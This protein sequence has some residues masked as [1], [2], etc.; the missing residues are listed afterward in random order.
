MDSVS[1]KRRVCSISE[2]SWKRLASSSTLASSWRAGGG[3]EHD[4]RRVAGKKD[5]VFSHHLR[6]RDTQKEG[7]N[8]WGMQECVCVCVNVFVVVHMSTRL[9]SQVR[10]CGENSP[11]ERLQPIGRVNI[12]THTHI[13]T[14]TH[15]II[16]GSEALYDVVKTLENLCV[17]TYP[18]TEM[19]R[20]QPPCTSLY[21]N[22]AHALRGTAKSRFSIILHT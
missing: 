14:C 22:S 1:V 3:V 4:C 21:N 13:H 16:E 7:R 5:S 6:G 20:K 11:R 2:E 10:C 15:I 18:H 9:S 12:Y 19:I 8:Q 17:Q